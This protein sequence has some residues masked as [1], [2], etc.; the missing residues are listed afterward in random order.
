METLCG[1]Q[2]EGPKDRFGWIRA[3]ALDYCDSCDMSLTFRSSVKTS[4]GFLKM[5]SDF[6]ID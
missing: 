3:K 2:F 1:Q 4:L 5:F 6:P